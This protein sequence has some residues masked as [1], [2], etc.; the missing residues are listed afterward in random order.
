DRSQ[1]TVQLGE[2]RPWSAFVT[3]VKSALSGQAASKGAGLRILTETISSPSLAAHIQQ[4]LSTYPEARWV[5]WE[6]LPDNARGGARLAFGAPVA[7]LYDFTKADVVLSL[8]ADFL[9]SQGAANLRYSRQFASRR[10]I[11]GN[12]E[13]LNR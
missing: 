12:G 6:A 5:Q 7:P 8:D 2:I 3:A 13:T 11:E 10:R 4:V 9:A 1:S